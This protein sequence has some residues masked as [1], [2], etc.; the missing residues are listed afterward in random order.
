MTDELEFP[1]EELG[2]LVSTVAAASL[3][4]RGAGRA[5]ASE[6][7]A[8]LL[9]HDERCAIAGG[10]RERTEVTFPGVADVDAKAV[11]AA[12]S[13]GAQPIVAEQAL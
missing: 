3:P 13:G 11:V 7:L 8:S 6:K 2:K 1:L 12:E 10:R 4:G 9:R 5:A